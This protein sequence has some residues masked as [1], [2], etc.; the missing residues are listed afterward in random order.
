M[1]LMGRLRFKAKSQPLL[2]RLLLYAILVAA[3]AGVLY[4]S[5]AYVAIPL[6]IVLSPTLHPTLYELG[7]YGGS[8][9]QTYISNGLSSPRI[10]TRKSDPQCDK[11]YTFLN[12]NGA[13]MA[14][15]GP[16]IL[17]PDNELVWKLETEGTT[18][19]LKVQTYKGEQ[20]VTYWT[21]MKGG[22]M[23]SGVYHMLDSSYDVKH[24][25]SAVGLGGDLHEFLI[26]KDDTA[27]LTFYNVTPAD[28]SSLG[29][30]K[31]GWL[32]DSGF[33]E[34]DIATGELLFEWRASEHFQVN[35][36]F[37][38][39]PF[40]GYF[41]SI[42]FDFFHINSV[43]KDSKGNYLISSR[44]THSVS[45]IG[46]D[47]QMLWILGGQRNQFQ[48]LSGGEALTFRW[49]HDAR[50]VDEEAGIITLFDNKEGGPLHIDGPYSRGM[51]LQL[52]V[53]NRTV[54]FLHSYISLHHTRA[55]SQGSTQYLPASRHVFVGFGHSPVLSE[56]TLN[57]TLL[58]ETHYGAPWL[59]VF[60]TA[61]SY[62]AFKSA[63]WVGTP[64][65]PPV[66]KILDDTLYVSWNG[67]TEVAA[68]VLQGASEHDEGFVDLDVVYKESY[69]ETFELEQLSQYSWFRVAALDRNGQVLRST[70]VIQRES[71]SSWWT[72][73]L[74]VFCWG[75]LFRAA[76]VA[77][78]WSSER[79]HTGKKGVSWVVWRKS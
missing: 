56:F 3:G 49:Q 44:H 68:W 53:P 12:F 51:M 50:W 10:S 75:V 67:A 7:L 39:H 62:R 36:T 73:L 63:N 61:V 76:W 59:H 66:A 18:T 23:G 21:G 26:T 30:T 69:E 54:T 72:F 5:V 17:D 42:P 8:P 55:P 78:K 27:L 1:P 6:L 43:D 13:S 77:Y 34:V 25:V 58:C 64:R 38:T 14:R 41:K 11:A 9:S 71:S 4:L 52:D 32:I 19:N 15:S 40:G 74:A 37:M 2:V 65:Q 47:G 33:Q 28:L 31:T 60:D 16:A 35:E 24:T 57:G 22:T 70:D 79:G 48:D 29:K 46:P 45:C 20:Y